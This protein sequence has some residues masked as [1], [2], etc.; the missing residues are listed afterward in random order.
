MMASLQSKIDEM[1]IEKYESDMPGS[2]AGQMF[3]PT[4][5]LAP[6]SFD[7]IVVLAQKQKQA[8]SDAD[9]LQLAIVELDDIGRQV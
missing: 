4:P 7:R 2:N 1:D 8:R 6:V 5:D 9:L 3:N